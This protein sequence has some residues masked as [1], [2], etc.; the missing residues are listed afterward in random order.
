[1]LLHPD[2]QE[3]VHAELDRELPPGVQPTFGDRQNLPYLD[4][5]WRES[6]RMHPSTPICVP[7]VSLE[8]TEYKGWF[9]PKG[10]SFQITL[11]YVR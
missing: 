3:K 5:V 2:V 8:D 10:T 7:H 4:A 1:M 9:I 6:K 11:G